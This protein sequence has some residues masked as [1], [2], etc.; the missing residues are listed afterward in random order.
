MGRAGIYLSLLVIY[1]PKGESEWFEASQYATFGREVDEPGLGL[2]IRIGLP[3]SAVWC[4][5]T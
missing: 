1:S 3:I 5:D 4:N 2:G